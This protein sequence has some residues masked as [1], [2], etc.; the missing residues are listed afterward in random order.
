MQ[1][2]FKRLSDNGDPLILM[3][4]LLGSSDNL[5][6]PAKILSTEYSVYLID[7]RNHG[8]SPHHPEMNYTVMSDDLLNFMDDL[9]IEKAHIFGHSMGGKVAMHFALE[10]E[11]RLLTLLVGDIAPMPYEG[12][13]QRLF[14]AMLEMPLDE[15]QSRE[16][17]ENFLLPRIHSASLRQFLLKNLAREGSRFYWRPAVKILWDN[18]RLLMDFTPGGN[19]CQQPTAFIR[20][21]ESD[22]IRPA[23][24]PYYETI[25]PQA[26]LYTVPQAGHWLH[27][28]QPE[29]FISIFKQALH[30]NIALL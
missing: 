20:G 21:A 3:H 5:L 16:D 1:L 6:S 9:D 23:D 18:Y 25:F 12:D 24:F 8:R 27:A 19:V 28:D 22:Y 11:E 15:I 4:G 29:L 7:L 2:Y 13:H 30:D 26:R 17:A 14:K 10:H